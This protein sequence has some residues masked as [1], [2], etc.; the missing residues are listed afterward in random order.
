ML[1]TVTRLPEIVAYGRTAT[2]ARQSRSL[3]GSMLTHN[4]IGIAHNAAKTA[5]AHQ[6]QR[7]W[8]SAINV[9]TAVVQNPEARTTRVT[10]LPGPENARRSAP[11]LPSPSTTTAS[12]ASV[13][14][15]ATRASHRGL[16]AVGLSLMASAGLRWWFAA[17]VRLARECARTGR[18][19]VPA[20]VPVRW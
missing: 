14:P 1:W 20:A 7:R 2:S 15:L 17:L 11:Q 8:K 10:E 19:S 4:S 5:K 13:A 12:P 9:T 18:R 3:L 6:R 16:A